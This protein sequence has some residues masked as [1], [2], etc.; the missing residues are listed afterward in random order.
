VSDQEG[1]KI[2]QPEPEPAPD[3]QEIL[4]LN[5]WIG[6]QIS[7]QVMDEETQFLFEAVRANGQFGATA[8][9]AVYQ[10][11]VSLLMQ[12]LSNVF[13]DGCQMLLD[14]MHRV[15]PESKN[16]KPPR[17]GFHA[18]QGPTPGRIIVPE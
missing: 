15:E 9:D 16:W 18:G 3:D 1:P 4:I 14:S 7:E 11:A 12:K 8:Q 6:W 10:T 5:Q 13:A 2:Y 17:L